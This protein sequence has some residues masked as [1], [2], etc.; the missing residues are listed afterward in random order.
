MLNIKWQDH[1]TNISVLEKVHNPKSL[2]NIILKQKLEYFGHNT[3]RDGGNLEKQCMEGRVAD[4]AGRG[5]LKARWTDNICAL[6]KHNMHELTTT[7]LDRE[8]CREF[9][10]RTPTRR[11]TP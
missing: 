6:K 7:A 8:A 3:R 11:W 1:T 5:R 4:R 2:V 9:V 10:S